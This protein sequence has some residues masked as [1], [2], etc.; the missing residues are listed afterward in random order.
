METDWNLSPEEWSL[1]TR[2]SR[3][4]S[5]AFPYDGNM[6]DSVALHWYNRCQRTGESPQKLLLERCPNIDKIYANNPGKFRRGF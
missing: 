1:M 5:R 4:A 2:C 6:R 3:A